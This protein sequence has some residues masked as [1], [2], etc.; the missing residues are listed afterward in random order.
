ME[1][2]IY[3]YS[4]QFVELVN[5]RKDNL[6]EVHSVD[7]SQLWIDECKNNI[8]SKYFNERI[9][10][11]YLSELETKEFQGRICTLYKKLPNISPDLIY[12]CSYK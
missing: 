8:D 5:L 9:S 1:K 4:K 11:I 6:F 12:L 2:K 7:N 3:K 10:N